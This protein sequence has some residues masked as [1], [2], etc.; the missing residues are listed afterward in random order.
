VEELTGARSRFLRDDE[1]SLPTQVPELPWVVERSTEAGAARTLADLAQAERGVLLRGLLRFGAVLF[2]GFEVKEAEEFAT[3]L[4]ALGLDLSPRFELEPQGRLKASKRT[5]RST[6]VP[7]WLPIAPHTEMAYSLFRPGKIAFH[8]QFR[9]AGAGGET[10][11]FD[12][13]NVAAMMDD[14]TRRRFRGV[15]H[16][17]HFPSGHASAGAVLEREALAAACTRA[18]YALTWGPNGDLDARAEFSAL[19]R[20]PVT[21]EVVLNYPFFWSEYALTVSLAMARLF[22]ERVPSPWA[23]ALLRSPLAA[24]VAPLLAPL[25]KDRA[26]FKGG[27]PSRREKQ[28]MLGMLTRSASIFAWRKGDV[29]VVDNFRVGH[30]KLPHTGM[31]KVNVAIADM[32][33]VREHL[34]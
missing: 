17:R 6:R 33:D 3:A 9:G 15:S 21:G 10:P 4:A 19:L 30:G 11:L 34:V 23:R 13:R 31:R 24:A 18:G 26:R 20:H 8:F 27:G 25:R 1:R 32:V 2:R 14:R 22:V 28:A 29:L 5:F 7:D 12:F 16:E